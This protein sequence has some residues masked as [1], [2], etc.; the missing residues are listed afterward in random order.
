MIII[1]I[2]IIITIIINCFVCFLV[3]WSFRFG[4]LGGFAYSACITCFVSVVSCWF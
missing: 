4:R 1:I 3:I 2:I